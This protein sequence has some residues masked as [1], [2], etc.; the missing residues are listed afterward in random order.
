MSELRHI[1][2]PANL[3][4]R[5]DDTPVSAD[6]DDIYFST[7]D[8]A[9]ESRYVFL[10]QN[11]LEQR[12]QAAQKIFSIGETGFGSGLNFL[13]TRELWERLQPH[14][15]R[16]HY[17]SV[18]QHPMRRADLQRALSCFPALRQFAD[19]LIDRYPPL[20]SGHHILHFRQHSITLH[21]L[22]GDGA[23]MLR[24]MLCTDCGAGLQA[25]DNLPANG[26]SIDAWFLD[27]FAPRANPALWSQE[28]CDTISRLSRA[29]TTLSTFSAAASVKQ[30]L[31]AAGFNIAKIRGFGCKRDMLTA[32]WQRHPAEP[33][34]KKPHSMYDFPRAL[35][36]INAAVGDCANV[37]VIGG[38][39]VGCCTALSLARRGYRV[40]LLE[41]GPELAAAASGNAQVSLYTRLS[42]YA[43]PLNDF[44]LA[45]YFYAVRYYRDYFL[46]QGEQCGLLQL[47]DSA[48]EEKTYTALLKQCSDADVMRHCG[49]AEASILAGIAIVK[50][51]VY[52]PQSGW[53]APQPLCSRLIDHPNIQVLLST[54]VRALHRDAGGWRL[55]HTGTQTLQ[56]ADAVVVAMGQH[57]HTFPATSFLPLTAIRGQVSY[58]PTTAASDNL[59]TVI[60][61]RSFITPPS[62][63][64]HTVG[65]S[66]NQAAT[67]LQLSE[68]D[69]RNNMQQLA[70]LLP[71]MAPSLPAPLRGRVGFRS[72]APD[73]LPVVGPV[74]EQTAF[75]RDYAALSKDARQTITT[76]SR[77]L[78]GLYV[79]SAYG[80]RAYCL[81][82][83]CAELLASQIS[84]EPA[85]LPAYIT[86]AL[87]P[88]RFMLR[89]IIH[90]R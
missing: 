50:N 33:A 21:L 19:E 90:A 65:A 62:H 7:D 5:D 86:R 76:V 26:A 85:P 35:W 25:T 3:Q 72:V 39:I 45:A 16:L 89:D 32:E 73:Y 66:Y 58:V 61:E 88:G 14:S 27:G 8:G 53:L 77:H 9:A 84:G 36:Y 18:E 11:Q 82:P 43:S 60:C 47:L 67:C 56:V 1:L 75:K 31:Q 23:P 15:S 54:R 52:F 22:F 57:S 46:H 71:A 34:N 69:H 81:A 63:G 42:P 68:Q 44:A 6:Y 64:L 59:R 70:A 48:A 87:L 49:S 13:L 28:L 78:S 17:I 83:L 74:P 20:V 12:W 79:N 80:S 29:G 2:Q 30:H 38:G 37:T 40:Q 51:A 41:Q 4:W 10:Q 24:Q 55:D